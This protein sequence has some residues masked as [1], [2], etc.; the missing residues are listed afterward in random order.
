MDL[1][2]ASQIVAGRRESDAIGL[3]AEPL[4][5]HRQIHFA[6]IK[7]LTGRRG[8]GVEFGRHA[9]FEDRK[10]DREVSVA[11]KPPAVRAFLGTFRLRLL[12]RLDQFGRVAVAPE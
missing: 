3:T 6:W 2:V 11:Q 1:L 4:E 9:A 10:L 5:L 8:P 12:R 7:W